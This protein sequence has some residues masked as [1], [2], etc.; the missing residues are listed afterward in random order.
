MTSIIEINTTTSHHRT[1]D[2]IQP[3]GFMGLA[4]ELRD[5][6]YSYMVEPRR[7]R[8]E[9]TGHPSD[10][11]NTNILR[12]NRQI[13]S[14]AQEIIYEQM[15]TVIVKPF[16]ESDLVISSTKVFEGLKFKRCGIEVDSSGRNTKIDM[17]EDTYTDAFI[18]RNWTR[19]VFDHLTHQLHRMPGLEELHIW[20]PRCTVSTDEGLGQQKDNSGVDD[21]EMDMDDEAVKY[22]DIAEDETLSLEKLRQRDDAIFLEVAITYFRRL[23]DTI[24]VTIEGN[25]S[26]EDSK[27]MLSLMD[28]CGSLWPRVTPQ[29]SKT[30]LR[31]FAVDTTLASCQSDGTRNISKVLVL[32]LIFSRRGQRG[33]THEC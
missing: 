19:D 2:P 33:I 17:R 31:V 27:R 24:N 6:I 28:D 30:R 7:S 11:F 26:S 22:K 32:E 4:R 1:A 13:R 21:S 3:S 16:E 5:H 8:A 14:E 25:L 23:A 20:S 29:G 9:L 10:W 18:K 15:I 12:T